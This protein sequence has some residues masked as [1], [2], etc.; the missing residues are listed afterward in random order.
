LGQ[1]L[2]N[3]TQHAIEAFYAADVEVYNYALH[4]HRQQLQ[5]VRSLKAA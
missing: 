4:L 3:I 5:Y 1:P 2:P